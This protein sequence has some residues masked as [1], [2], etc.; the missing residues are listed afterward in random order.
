MHPLHLHNPHGT[1][2][3]TMLSKRVMLLLSISF[4]KHL[5]GNSHLYNL[6]ADSRT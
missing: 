3:F 1:F 2:S 4:L 6:T 5:N